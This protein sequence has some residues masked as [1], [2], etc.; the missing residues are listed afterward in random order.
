MEINSNSPSDASGT[1]LGT[2]HKSLHQMARDGDV[3]VL[4]DYIH[5]LE[6]NEGISDLKFNEL[7]DK[8][9]SPLHYA[10]RYCNSEMVEFIIERADES[11]DI[12][13]KGD[14]DMTPLHYVA[15]YGKRIGLSPRKQ[16]QKRK[17]V[18][19]GM[20]DSL[21][22]PILSHRSMSPASDVVDGDSEEEIFRVVQIL[23]IHF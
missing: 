16:R 19:S 4:K 22:S 6:V 2:E 5:L 14:D 11:F 10:A 20:G 18:V 1:Y 3:Q 7:D 12:N 8:K 15:R 13:Q 21:T 9:L 23:G 17:S